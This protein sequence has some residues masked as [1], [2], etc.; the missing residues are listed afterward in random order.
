MRQRQTKSSAPCT[1][2]M[3]GQEA[4]FGCSVTIRKPGTPTVMHMP[5]CTVAAVR[6][7]TA[8]GIFASILTTEARSGMSVCDLGSKSR[9]YSSAAI[10]FW[11]S[12]DR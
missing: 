5:C 1:L 8:S 7:K 9:M 2:M 4:I 6:K 10:F 3:N 11:Q 12:S